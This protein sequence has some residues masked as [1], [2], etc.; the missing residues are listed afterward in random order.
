MLRITL[1]AVVPCPNKHHEPGNPYILKFKR[2]FITESYAADAHSYNSFNFQAYPI[3]PHTPNLYILIISDLHLPSSSY[4]SLVYRPRIL[5][6]DI[7]WQSKNPTQR[8]TTDKPAIRII[9]RLQTTPSFRSGTIDRLW[10]Q[11][12]DRPHGRL[13]LFLR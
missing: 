11:Q 13:R 7:L 9:S 5:H 3:L 4:P 6:T 2:H 1:K 10:Q 12:T 8:S